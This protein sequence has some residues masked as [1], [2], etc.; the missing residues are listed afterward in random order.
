MPW[1]HLS[2]A[3]PA[4]PASTP[5]D[6]GRQ[7][8]Y[9]QALLEAQRQAL[10]A[11]AAVV[12]MGEGV[13]D[14]AGS[15]GTTLGLQEQFG[16]D[17]VFDL[18]LAEN[19]CMGLALGAALAGLRPIVVHLR[20]DFLLLALDQLANHAAK[21]RYMFH[22]RQTA[23][24]VVRCVVG[25]GWGS[26]AQHSQPLHGVLMQ[27]PGLKVA[28]P[29]TPHDAKGL[30]LAA[31]AD[32]GPVVLLEH[33]WLYDD[34]GPVPE[35]AYGV[36]LGRAAVRR[37]GKDVTI[38]AVSLMVREA[39]AAAEI[40]TRTGVSAEVLDLRTVAPMDTA[41]L[42]AS[43][44]KTGRLVLA[45]TGHLRG[46]WAAEAAAVAAEQCLSCLKAPV[47][48]VGLPDAP[49]PASPVLEAA[50]YPGPEAIV[51]AVEQVVRS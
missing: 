32:A 49:T 47:A 36:P 34:L 24:L 5:S 43:V 46:G 10:A 38:A 33:R 14:A 42:V 28:L 23:P 40:L 51:Q 18:P 50:Y 37:K 19:G 1:T 20:A 35:A 39:L 29:A 6:A 4:Q 17:R 15:F 9:R 16:A 25:R 12:V 11:D 30:L 2:A 8:T 22:A 41:A 3:G 21:W 13:D 44:A 7:L 26:A 48:R 27:F 45:D 31:I